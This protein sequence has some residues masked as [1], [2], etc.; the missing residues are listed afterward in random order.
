M[1]LQYQSQRLSY[2]CFRIDLHSCPAFSSVAR[3]AS[4]F[5]RLDF[6]GHSSTR[7][8]HQTLVDAVMISI[9]GVGVFS[10]CQN[11][12]EE[13]VNILCIMVFA[14]LLMPYRITAP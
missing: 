8:L 2:C 1:H 7:R 14:T 6:S 5:A 11:L 4:G 12:L 10:W 9:A 13:T 3:L